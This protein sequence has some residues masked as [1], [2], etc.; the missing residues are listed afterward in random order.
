MRILLCRLRYDNNY[1]Y[2]KAQRQYSYISKCYI[3]INLA[4]PTLPQ[5]FPMR[6]L[7]TKCDNAVKPGFNH[8]EIRRPEMTS[9]KTSPTELKHT[10]SQQI[11]GKRLYTTCWFSMRY[12]NYA[13]LF[14]A[15]AHAYQL[16]VCRVIMGLRVQ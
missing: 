1:Y 16:T 10:E 6:L 3:E 13:A 11:L 7:T 12:S 8:M 5:P 9:V 4:C 15:F 2:T 14:L